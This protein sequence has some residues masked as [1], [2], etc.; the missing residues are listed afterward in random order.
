MRS[1]AG[2]IDDQGFSNFPSKRA[3]IVFEKL[4][5]TDTDSKENYPQ[6]P[7]PTKRRMD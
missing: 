1:F 7:V 5:Q 6:R 2:N 3:V 4:A